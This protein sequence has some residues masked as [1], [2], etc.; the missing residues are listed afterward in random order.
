MLEGI[1]LAGE[2]LERLRLAQREAQVVGEVLRYPGHRIGIVAGG[3][4]GIERIEEE[5]GIHLR[6]E[7][8]Q[9]VLAR[10]RLGASGA[11]DVFR[12]LDL[13]Q[14]LVVIRFEAEVEAAPQP[15]DDH[16]QRLRRGW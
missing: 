11:G 14:G 8:A 1:E 4:D 15:G 7:V 6:F 9:L 2:G 3:D 12:R 10:G 5:V 16:P 13:G